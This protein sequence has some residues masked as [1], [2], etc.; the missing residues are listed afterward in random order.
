MEGTLNKPPRDLPSE[1]KLDLF[2]EILRTFGEAKLAVTGT[3]MLPAIWPRDILSVRSHDVVQAVPG[4]IIVFRHGGRLV[5]HRVAERVDCQNGIK[6]VTRGD[7]AC[8][9]D[10]P[11]LSDELLGRVTAV[12]RGSHWFTPRRSLSCRLISWILCR[13]DLAARSLLQLGKLSFGNTESR[14]RTSER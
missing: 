6:W 9:N 12:K 2:V 14:E 5:A 13:S 7:S 1:V 8:G 11:V 4:D 3:S 10:I